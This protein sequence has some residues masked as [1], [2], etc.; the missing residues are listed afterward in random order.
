MG[1]ALLA[2]LVFTWPLA[3]H[4]LWV[5]GHPAG[6]A[7]NH[8]WMLWRALR[9]GVGE[10]AGQPLANLPDGLPIPLMD[11]INLALALPGLLIDPALGYSQALVAN[12][13]LA[14]AA[15]WWL[16]RELGA[17]RGGA[18]VAG[19]GALSA[20]FLSGVIAFGITES[21]SAGWIGLHA[22]ALLAWARDGRARWLALASGCLAAFALSGWYH[23]LFGLVV[24]LPLVVW[25]LRRGA[26]L[27]GL[28]LQGAV[29][30]LAVLPRLLTFL[31]VR[32]FWQ[33]RWRP[34]LGAPPVF[35]PQWRE[36][37]VAGTDLLNLLLP[38]LE[39]VPI[40]KSVYLGLAL[41][42][43]A[44]AAGRRALPLLAICLP[45]WALALGHWLSVGGHTELLGRQW[46]LPALWLTR[47]FPALEGLSHWHRAAGP[48]VVF[49]AAAAGLGAE[50]LAG[51]RAGWL[52]GVVLLDSLLFSQTPW[53]R[54]QYD[55]RPPAAYAALEGPGAVVQL[56]FDN[57]REEFDP[58]AVP[59][60]YNR[61]QPWIDRPVAENYEGP[62]AMLRASRLIA[63]A[64][65]LC[66]VPST[67][68]RSWSPAAAFSDPA[69]L[70]RPALRQ[71]AIT[72]LRGWGVRWIVLH[73]ERGPTTAEAAALLELALGS[74]VYDR[75]GIAVYRLPD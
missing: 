71:Q 36:T 38:S 24:E 10:L 60:I 19:V 51:A 58:E 48:A 46:S 55:P 70:Q 59:R 43:L 72:R 40:S 29:A 47:A 27:P 73:R 11:P 31:E 69:P 4:P 23:A 17:G 41:L 54:D 16:A 20:P 12:L 45:L 44:L 13:A 14:F 1:A 67:Q 74:P 49:L 28:L 62:D 5:L 56:P 37:P 3:R 9:G 39:T 52:A 63:A 66:G 35:Q 25:A 34:P 32:G 50:R 33:G 30:G 8:L 26:R 68:P 75:E 18:L 15:G 64:D 57:G 7:D 65:R 53:P 21:W 2:G 61:W 6:E 42:T 22:A